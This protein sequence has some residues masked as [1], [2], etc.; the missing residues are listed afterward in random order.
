[1]NM[2]RLPPCLLLCLPALTLLFGC[3]DKKASSAKQQQYAT[4]SDRGVGDPEI[5]NVLRDV[6]AR[7]GVPAMAA[8][9][10]T[11]QGLQK[12]AAVGTRKA[13]TDVPVTLDDVWHLGSN[14]KIMTSTIVAQ[15]IEQGRLSW[16]TTV[17]E[18]FPDLASGFDPSARSITILQLLSH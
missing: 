8:A 6:S 12:V 2:R 9:L 14:T 5:L 13:G 10:V 7:T 3:V 11:S 16:T 1:M 4:A 17:S 18:V 15:L